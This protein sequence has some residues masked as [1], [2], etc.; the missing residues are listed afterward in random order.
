[1][2]RRDRWNAV[3]ASYLGWTLDAFDF[4]ILIF[5]VDTLAAQFHVSK[6]A[7]IGTLTA[8]LATRPLGAVVFGLLAD[9][10]GRR[11]PLMANIVFF[12]LIEL[13]CGFSP[14]YSVFLALRILY[15][16]GMGGEW[17]VGASLA[18]E[19]APKRLR[20]VLSGALQ[21]GYSMGYLL[22]AV[23]ARVVLPTLG[24]RAMFWI[25]GLPALLALYIRS[26]VKESE[27][28]KEHRIPTFRAAIETAASHW[29]LFGYLVIMM[30]LM[31]CLSHGTQDLYPDFLR[32]ARG[33]TGSTVSYIA[34]V[35]NIGAIIGSLAFGQFSQQFGRRKSMT[36][37]L[38]LALAAIP[39]WIFS[40]SMM[41]FVIGAFLLQAGVQGAWGIVPAHINELSPGQVRG[42]L[43]GFAY[44]V[45]ILFAAGTGTIEYGLRN[46][47]GYS[48]ALAGFEIVTI[49]LLLVVVNAGTERRYIDF[50]TRL[51]D[52][53][54]CSSKDERALQ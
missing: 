53:T 30:T 14:N 37:A 20:G 36:A 44:Q 50:S 1:M 8:T 52:L 48:V 29:K 32:S 12:S 21:S 23:A 9:R 2:T 33:A 46:R 13:L 35:Y 22:A 16:I 51:P 54:P 47:F 11:G 40:K 15:G 25:G 43:P 19:S 39:A 38:L 4:F 7:I 26:H 42:L 6:S 17:G 10:Y 3:I 5:L 24:W 45:G 18:M 49:V 28:W 27:A 31:V 34:I 41:V